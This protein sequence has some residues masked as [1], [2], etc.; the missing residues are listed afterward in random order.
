VVRWDQ[1]LK[2]QVHGIY[3]VMTSTTTGAVIAVGGLAFLAARLF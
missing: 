1:G 2:E 3:K